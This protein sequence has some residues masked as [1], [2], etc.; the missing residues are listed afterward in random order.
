MLPRFVGSLVRIAPNHI[1]IADP[2]AFR[3]IYAHGT[4]G[5]KGHFYDA[6]VSTRP[7]LFNTR[8]RA[9]H[10]RKRKMVSHIFSLKSVLEYE[11][12]I[13][14][15]AEAL[16]GQWDK[17]AEGGKKGLSGKEA[18]G[19]FGRDGCVW[20]DTL[21]CQLTSSSLHPAGTD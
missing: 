16:L 9:E 4:G 12:Y 3:V 19:W 17:L 5:L 14:I 11:P 2:A 10:S 20:Y 7:N 21:L 15:H 13:R 18:D 6:T 8:N 1:S